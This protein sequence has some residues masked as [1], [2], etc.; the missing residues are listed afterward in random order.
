MQP[1]PWNM[2]L[3]PPTF[4][5]GV[6]STPAHYDF[7]RG[8]IGSDANYLFDTIARWHLGDEVGHREGG[9]HLSQEDFLRD[10]GMKPEQIVAPLERLVQSRIILR[11][12]PIRHRGRQREARYARWAIN[13]CLSD[14]TIVPFFPV[15]PRFRL[16][17]YVR[18]V[19]QGSLPPLRTDEER[20][21]LL[22]ALRNTRLD[23]HP[24]VPEQ[25]PAGGMR[26]LL[27]GALA[28]PDGQEIPDPLYFAVSKQLGAY[29]CDECDGTRLQF[30]P[31]HSEQDAPPA[32]TKRPIPNVLV[33]AVL[34]QSGMRCQIC[35]AMTLG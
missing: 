35:G 2:T 4:V 12:E 6:T 33:Q 3:E 21:A 17:Q 31:P 34:D 32:R 20:A 13:L 8:L 27:E 11:L 5:Q 18:I 25:W 10:T 23:S 22:R 28:E 1:E 24:P 29:D 15:M 30:V 26:E 9:G 19:E 16:R 14:W 7:V